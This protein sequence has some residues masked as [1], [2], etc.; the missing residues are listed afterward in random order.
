MGSQETNSQ[1][2]ALLYPEQPMNFRFNLCQCQAAKFARGAWSPEN[3]GGLLRNV[4]F[5]LPGL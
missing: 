1:L 3:Q 2:L 5:T 4:G